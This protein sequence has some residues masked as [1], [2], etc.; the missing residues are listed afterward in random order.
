MKKRLF[1]G[2]QPDGP[3]HIGNYLGSIKSWVKMQDDYECYF[4]AVDLHAM[5]IEYDT[6]QFREYVFDTVALFIACGVDPD[7]ATIFLQSHVSEHA[8][9]TWILNTLAPMGLLERMTQYKDKARVHSQN[10]NVG[11]FDYPVLQVADILLYKGEVVPVGSDQNQHLELSRD[12]ARKF[13]NRFGETFPEP[14]TVLSETPKIMGLDGVSKMS[15]SLGNGIMMLDTPEVVAKKIRGALT[16]PQRLRLND[17]GDPSVCN[18]FSLHKIFSTPEQIAMIDKE[19]RCAG[20]G[21]GDCKKII[22]ENI[23]ANLAPIQQRYNEIKKHPDDLYDIL[24]A[25]RL[26]ASAVAQATMAEVRKKT[27][28]LPL[29]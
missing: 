3:L 4:C 21:C 29:T 18:I 23:N 14:Q 10:V 5:T 9:L 2:I 16:D 20:I 24:K 25:G 13:N 26:K 7:K 22:I 15:K 19:C 28:L 8:E 11:L 1:S 12:L 17:P 27:G 6:A